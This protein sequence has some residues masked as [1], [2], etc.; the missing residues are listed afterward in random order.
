MTPWREQYASFAPLAAG[1]IRLVEILP[2]TEYDIVQASCTEFA[3]QEAPIYCALS[4]TWGSTTDDLRHILRNGEDFIVTRN[5]FEALQKFRSESEPVL[6]W[7]DAICINQVSDAECTQQIGLMVDIYSKAKEVSIW[8][9]THDEDPELEF[10]F[11]VADSRK[12][13]AELADLVARPTQTEEVLILAHEEPYYHRVL[14]AARSRHGARGL[15]TNDMGEELVLSDNDCYFITALRA[16]CGRFSNPWAEY[17]PSQEALDTIRT[18]S[19]GDGPLTVVRKPFIQAQDDYERRAAGSVTV[20]TPIHTF[21]NFDR[22]RVEA[23]AE[24]TFDTFEEFLLEVTKPAE[25]EL[26]DADMLRV[27]H[28]RRRLLQNQYW[29]RAWIVQE[30]IV[31]KV[32][33]VHWGRYKINLETLWRVFGSSKEKS[34]RIRNFTLDDMRV[35]DPAGPG[36]VASRLW[37]MDQSLVPE[38]DFGTWSRRVFTQLGYHKLIVRNGLFP[39]VTLADLLHDYAGQQALDP[40][41]RVFSLLN[42][43]R[44]FA[45]YE[46][47]TDWARS[48]CD[49]S[50]DRRAVFTAVATHFVKTYRAREPGGP[51]QDIHLLS[52]GNYL[53]P[54]SGHDDDWDGDALPSWVPAWDARR[55]VG[56]GLGMR[57][58]NEIDALIPYRF[59][60]EDDGAAIVMAGHIVDTVGARIELLRD[61][62]AYW[63]LDEVDLYRKIEAEGGGKRYGDQ[64]AVFA[65]FWRT[66]VADSTLGHKPEDDL[67]TSFDHEEQD[68]ASIWVASCLDNYTT[69]A[70][71]WGDMFFARRTLRAVEIQRVLN[72]AIRDNP[73]L[74]ASVRSFDREELQGRLLAE[75][76]ELQR[77]GM[78]PDQVPNMLEEPEWPADQ[79]RRSLL[80]LCNPAIFFESRTGFFALGPRG[81]RQG[82]VIALVGGYN[83][84]VCL[85]ERPRHKGYYQVV[86]RAWVS[87]L[88][89]ASDDYYKGWNEERVCD[90]TFR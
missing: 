66:V 36:Q 77:R 17:D 72:N 34:D 85:R 5:L 74:G 71:S 41:D 64:E 2:G 29:T 62:D 16:A 42:T 33:S 90:I 86:G 49:Y 7:I 1:W 8:L 20:I 25:L 51:V 37:A 67:S 60:I 27:L 82:D 78:Q 32:A 68:A 28:A 52:F 12:D 38:E 47:E 73:S 23:V 22:K 14:A 9:G 50:L 45:S 58:I 39:R 48:F 61:Y 54:L 83:F 56:D 35:G 18:R 70:D 55:W 43:L 88:M 59:R 11:R 69:I 10:L 63:M 3:L 57:R 75:I 31:S 89:Y 87:G 40:R 19:G 15:E 30:I 80:S 81:V 26:S 84:P 24:K 46:D 79:V 76:A 44:A 13:Y 6:M 53:P 21:P 4:Y 65:A